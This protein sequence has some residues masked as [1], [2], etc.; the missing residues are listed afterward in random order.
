VGP[1][2]APDAAQAARDLAGD[3]HAPVRRLRRVGGR[4][5][6]AVDRAG[7]RHDAE[8]P[9]QPRDGTSTSAARSFGSARRRARTFRCGSSGRASRLRS[10]R[11]SSRTARR[12]S[13]SRRS[14]IRS[15][16]APSV[17]CAA[18]SRRCTSCCGRWSART[19]TS[20]AAADRRP[21][22][23][24]AATGQVAEPQ[25]PD[26]GRCGRRLAAPPPIRQ[27][28]YASATQLAST[29][30]SV[31]VASSL[32]RN[33]ARPNGTALMPFLPAFRAEPAASFL[34]E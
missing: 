32:R 23:R 27:W 9:G 13:S 21:V 7:G 11:P 12:R 34:F 19:S 29:P 24:R 30:A 5:H 22:P 26:G 2:A 15:S 1:D 16:S 18:S 17:V 31:S 14:Q 25:M 8:R 10:R 33:S 6:A 3:G 20:G 4:S 28:T